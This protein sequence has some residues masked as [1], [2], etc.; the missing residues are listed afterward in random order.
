MADKIGYLSFLLPLFLTWKY[1][2]NKY[3]RLFAESSTFSLFKYPLQI[4]LKA[5]FHSSR[6]IEIDHPVWGKT[7]TPQNESNGK[8]EKR[9][10]E[11]IA[12]V[13]FNLYSPANDTSR[14]SSSSL[15][16]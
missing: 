12:L 16:Y 1:A 11:K 4:F 3:T 9:N 13:I 7:K 2:K 8:R 6:N 14:F 10:S 15:R 5:I